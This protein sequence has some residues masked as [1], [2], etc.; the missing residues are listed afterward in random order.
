[1]TQVG[2]RLGL[3]KKTTT[4]CK[5]MTHRVP[6]VGKTVEVAPRCMV[7]RDAMMWRL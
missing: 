3:S 6:E 4:L 5:S 7:G 1:M 2:W